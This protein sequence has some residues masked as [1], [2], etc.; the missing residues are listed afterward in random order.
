VTEPFRYPDGPAPFAEKTIHSSV[1]HYTNAEGLLGILQTQSIWASSPKALNDL[2]EI[3]FGLDAVREAFLKYFFAND[4]PSERADRINRILTPEIIEKQ[5]DSIFVL[6]AS[7]D[8]DLLNQWQHYSDADGF[9]VEIDTSLPLGIKSKDGKTTLGRRKQDLFF[10]GWYD[11][12]YSSDQQNKKIQEILTYVTRMT[13]DPS[14]KDDVLLY[15]VAGMIVLPQVARFKHDGFTDER[16][17]R[18]IS[19]PGEGNLINYRSS[20]NR[21]VPFIKLCAHEQIPAASSNPL[22]F[23]K[24]VVCGPTTH[25]NDIQI[26]RE[27]LKTYGL[28]DLKV[29]RS[30]IPFRK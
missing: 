9:A 5:I 19:G 18:Y 27:M 26:V 25:E 22:N 2:Q 11:V 30:R 28:G 14:Y 20:K 17:V 29:T 1:W 7:N 12:I 6:S 13:I 16:E 8:F 10:S 24:G 15:L 23:I 4:I 21:V 3:S